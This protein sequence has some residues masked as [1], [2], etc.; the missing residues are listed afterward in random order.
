MTFKGEW[1]LLVKLTDWD[2]VV[3]NASYGS[4]KIG[5][6]QSGYKLSISGYDPSSSTLGDGFAVTH[7]KLGRGKH[8]GQRFS[9]Y[10][11][12]QDGSGG[13]DCSNY[14]GGGGWWMN[15]CFY[16]NLNGGLYGRSSNEKGIYWYHGGKRGE[17]KSSWKASKMILIK[18]H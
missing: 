6:E 14:W 18:K 2:G 16:A 17:S 13:T 5:N 1:Q 15:R 3:Y 4:Y 12:D 7:D 10:D 9:T 11:K 8:H